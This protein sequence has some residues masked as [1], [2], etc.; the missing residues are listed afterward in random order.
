MFCHCD[1]L[2]NVSNEK[3]INRS[4]NGMDPYRAQKWSG[5]DPRSGRKLT[6]LIIII[7]IFIIAVIN[8]LLLGL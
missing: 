8:L 4:G 7:I 1:V 5:P 6:P 2:E 3:H